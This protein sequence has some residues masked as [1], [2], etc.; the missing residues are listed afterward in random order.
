MIIAE[1]APLVHFLLHVNALLLQQLPLSEGPVHRLHRGFSTGV[2]LPLSSGL[3]R[4]VEPEHVALP[5]DDAISYKGI[6]NQSTQVK[7]VHTN[8]SATYAEIDRKRN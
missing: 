6:V 8:V 2:L 1:S 7:S 4:V 5:Q 3:L